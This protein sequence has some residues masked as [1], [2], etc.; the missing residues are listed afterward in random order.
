MGQPTRFAPIHVGGR[1]IPSLYAATG[2]EAAA[3]ESIFHDIEPSATFRTVRQ[4]TVTNRS[5]SQI[6]P[7]RDLRLASLFAPDLAAWGIA[8]S[9]LVDTPRSAY[10]GSAVW[11]QAIHAAHADVDGLIWTSRRCDPHVCTVLFG[12]RVSEAD[13]DTI[14]RDEADQAHVLLRLRRYAMRSGITIV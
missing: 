9:D 13:I 12:D 14:G 7:R 4:D 2:E 11:A 10:P 8:R 6:A 5:V 1:C 3:F